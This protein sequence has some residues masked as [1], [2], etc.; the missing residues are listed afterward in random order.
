MRVYGIICVSQYN[1]FLLVKGVK[2]GKWS[3]PKGHLKEGE[4]G[5]A[6]ALRE[7][8]EETGLE[9]S[10]PY[11]AFRKLFAGEYYVY[12]VNECP[13]YPQDTREVCDSGWFSWEDMIR[14]DVNADVK[15]FL[16]NRRNAGILSP[17]KTDLRKIESTISEDE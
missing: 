11:C 12:S 8:K 15:R 17:P 13:V 10:G 3:F 9:V 7:L 4:L 1:T 2:T 14:M 5:H 6:C 16:A